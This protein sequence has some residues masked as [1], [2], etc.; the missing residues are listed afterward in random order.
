LKILSNKEIDGKDWFEFFNNNPYATP[1]QSPEYY[2]FINSLDGFKADVYSVEEGNELQALCVVTFQKEKGIKSFFSRRAIIYG[3]PLFADTKKGKHSLDSLIIAMNKKIGGKV[4]YA[5]TRNFHDYSKMKD[6]FYE[7]GWNY[8]PYLN[9]GILLQGKSR[10]D[11]LVAMKYNRRREIQLS[12]KEGAISEEAENIDDVTVLY[13]ILFD[14]YKSRVR[15]PLPDLDFFIK[16]FYSPIGKVFIIKHKE[17]IIGGSFC[18]YYQN[19]SIYT[20]YY[21]SLRNYHPKIFP[22]HLAI[23]AAIDFGLKNNLHKIDLMGAGKPEIEYGVRR[24]KSEFGGELIEQ[25]R[26]IKVFHPFLFKVGKL[27]LTILKKF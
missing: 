9:I 13:N 26:F 24:Y 8:E 21:C 20:V 19:K 4:I 12:F 2:Y 1:F 23:L 15:L 5:E 10:E 11:I 7:N 16:L 14:L 17:Q 3:G 25:G 18:L 6:C 27:G 22:A